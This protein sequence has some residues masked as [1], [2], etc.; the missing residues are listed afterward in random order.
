MQFLD[1]FR[2]LLD[3]VVE[4]YLSVLNTRTNEV[5]KVLTIMASIFIPLTF[6]SGIFGMNFEHMPGLESEASFPI[7]VSAMV[8][9][10]LGMLV[11]FRCRYWL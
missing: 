10:A 6:L 3:S 2:D 8:V 7:F 5:M 11:L 4:G 1:T 9:I